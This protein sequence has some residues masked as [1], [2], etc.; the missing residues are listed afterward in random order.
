M[1]IGKFYLYSTC[2]TKKDSK[3]LPGVK[4]GVLLFIPAKVA[5]VMGSIALSLTAIEITMMM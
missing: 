4:L 1:C 3:F 5:F 2:Y